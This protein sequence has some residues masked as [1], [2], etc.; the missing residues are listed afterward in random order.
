MTI[1]KRRGDDN[2]NKE[3][4]KRKVVKNKNEINDEAD[5]EDDIDEDYDEKSA[6]A[7][8]ALDENN[9]EN[10]HN[11]K[12]PKIQRYEDQ[13]RRGNGRGGRGRG[14]GFGPRRYHPYPTSSMDRHQPYPPSSPNHHTDYQRHREWRGRGSSHPRRP[15]RRL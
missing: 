8:E 3:T 9:E 7:E 6:N 14:R 11:Y 15:T 13:P 2:K 5:E 10:A 4:I 1:K 12:K